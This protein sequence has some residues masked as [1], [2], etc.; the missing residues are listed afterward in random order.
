MARGQKLYP[1]ATV[2]K[3]VKAHSNCSVSKNVDITV[4]L[5][6]TLETRCDAPAD[7]IE[8][9]PRLRSLHAEV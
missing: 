5:D 9:L 1:R 6:L 8:D 7:N 3:I 2:K 4:R